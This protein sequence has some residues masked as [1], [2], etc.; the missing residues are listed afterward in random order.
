VSPAIAPR[1]FR[2]SANAAAPRVLKSTEI[3]LIVEYLAGFLRRYI[4]F[5]KPSTPSSSVYNQVFYNQDTKRAFWELPEEGQFNEPMPESSHAFV[6][7][8]AN[9]RESATTGDKR[10]IRRR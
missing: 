1:G 6:Q 2:R 7:T 8:R 9:R 4:L 3:V 10:E 5:S